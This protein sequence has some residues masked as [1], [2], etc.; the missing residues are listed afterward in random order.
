M[1]IQLNCASCGS[2]NFELDAGQTDDCA[3][4]CGECGHVIGTMG[5][6]KAKLAQEV[7]R[8]ARRREA[9]SSD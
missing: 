4:S 6:L 5:E 3:V 2:N 7:I 1:R 8:Q 9:I